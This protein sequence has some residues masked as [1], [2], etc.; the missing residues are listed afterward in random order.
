MTAKMNGITFIDDAG[1]EFHSF[2]FYGLVL[3][4]KDIGT[5]AIKSQTVD[6]NGMDGVL[7]LTDYFGEVT[8]E[9]RTLTFEFTNLDMSYDEFDDLFSAIQNDLHGLNAKVIVDGDEDF[10]YTGRMNVNEW[11]SDKRIGKITIECDCEPYK[12]R[13]EQTVVTKSLTTA[14]LTFPLY[15]LRKRVVPTFETTAE[16]HIIFG[17]QNYAVASGS[18]YT[19]EDLVLGAGVNELTAYTTSGT[20]TLTITYQERGL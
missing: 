2:E 1:N 17:S 9:N 15:N 12:Y 7:D 13:K 5:P 6:I 19:L 10:Y 3:S 18:Q 8:Y 20:A 11:K 4:S 14:H 16:T